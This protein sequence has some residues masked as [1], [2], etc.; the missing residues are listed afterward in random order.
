M[1]HIKRL[2]LYSTTQGRFGDAEKDVYLHNCYPERLK[3]GEEGDG[4]SIHVDWVVK[5]PG[6]LSVGDTDATLST[7]TRG[8][9][10]WE[11]TDKCYF[12]RGNLLYDVNAAGTISTVTTAT[13]SSSTGSVYISDFDSGTE[14][15]VINDGNNE[16]YTLQ[17]DGTLTLQTDT[18]INASIAPGVAVIDG[19]W[20]FMGGDSDM[21]IYNSTTAF[22]AAADMAWSSAD[23]ARI[24]LYPGSG[25]YLTRH[26]NYVAVFTD[27]SMEF[28][29]NAGN[30][31]GSPF[32]RADGTLR[33]VGT[34]WP[35]TIKR[36]ADNLIFLA[37]TTV[38]P[39]V[40]LLDG[41]QIKYV[42]TTP[43]EKI[44]TSEANALDGAYGDIID[45]AGQVF[46][47]LQ[48]PEL[49]RTLVWSVRTEHWTEWNYYNGSTYGKFPYRHFV[50]HPTAAKTFAM[51]DTTG[52][53]FQF[54]AG[55]FQD[56]G[57]QIRTR[58]QTANIDFETRQ[59]KFLW[60]LALVGDEVSSVTFD[61]SDDDYNN[62]VTKGTSS[63]TAGKPVWF[64][65]GSFARRAFR[66]T[67]TANESFRQESMELGM[68]LGH[69]AN[70]DD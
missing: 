57:N 31:T 28:F 34:H 10:Y 13:L 61:Y 68:D 35:D 41:L 43:I 59:Q 9:F 64:A 4:S 70:G 37:N 17:T 22:E 23:E 26:L 6:M 25:K 16:L 11:E 66:F 18:S 44:L 52:E 40:C 2:P 19:Y 38:G 46:Y 50:Y 15:L 8:S 30:A 33:Q 3:T 51:H 55:T 45:H 58:I 42:S 69:Y 39:K 56:D 47:L 49:S 14:K 67:H 54:D 5:R 62:Y 21:F 32:S 29:Y 53:V 27:K 20:L 7:A 12:A 1:K 48:L 24:Q 63:A 36:Y 65:N 60:S